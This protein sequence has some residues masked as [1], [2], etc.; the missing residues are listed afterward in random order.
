[1]HHPESPHT[2]A[3]C[4]EQRQANDGYSAFNKGG[5][6][7]PERP[8]PPRAVVEV[9]AACVSVPSLHRAGARESAKARSR[10][11]AWT[12]Q[13]R[14]H[15]TMRERS[16]RPEHRH[17]LADGGGGGFSAHRRAPISSPEAPT[18]GTRGA[19]RAPRRSPSPTRREDRVRNRGARRRLS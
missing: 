19:L 6:G 2:S 13:T 18:H 14:R 17:R 3:P 15:F 4:Q 8:R 7:R 16:A 5:P 11:S 9:A 12:R 10:G 1:M